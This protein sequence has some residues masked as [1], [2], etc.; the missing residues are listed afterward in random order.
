MRSHDLIDHGEV[1]AGEP[2]LND[3]SEEFHVMYGLIGC[4]SVVRHV[5]LNSV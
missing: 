3:L 4:L 2:I 5:A 1:G